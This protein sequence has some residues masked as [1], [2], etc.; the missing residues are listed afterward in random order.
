MVY[1]PF[2]WDRYVPRE[3]DVPLLHDDAGTRARRR[4]GGRR[5][6]REHWRPREAE[7]GEDLR[8]LYV[9]L[10]RARCQVVAWWVPATTTAASPLHR[11]LFGGRRPGATLAASYRS[12]PTPRRSTA[13]R[14]LAGADLAVEQVRE[15]PR[16]HR[17]RARPEALAAARFPGRSTWR[18]GGRRTAR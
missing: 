11:L 18:G 1:V 12:R 2:G 8:L 15:R 7:A 17:R 9:A 16:R 3:P 6:G 13:L 14:A 4:R 5:A 10:T